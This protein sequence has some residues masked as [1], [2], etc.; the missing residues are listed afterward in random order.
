MLWVSFGEFALRKGSGLVVCHCRSS[1]ED[2]S[3]PR[4]PRQKGFP[5]AVTLLG[6]SS[7]VDLRQAAG[8]WASSK[9]APWHS[10]SHA[11]G[12][13][14]WLERHWINPKSH[15]A[16]K[17]TTKPSAQC[18]CLGSG[19][20][21]VRTTFWGEKTSNSCKDT[22]KGNA[23]TG[24][25]EPSLQQWGSHCTQARSGAHSPLMTC[26]TYL[27]IIKGRTSKRERKKEG[28]FFY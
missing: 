28:I 8:W 7:A 15:V 10:P 21:A 2:L 23:S 19:G 9:P 22:G 6:V 16:K 13:L 3:S 17:Q 27:I 1:W 4:K 12:F 11:S 14:R 20:N 18:L 5:P 25:S 26:S 24:R